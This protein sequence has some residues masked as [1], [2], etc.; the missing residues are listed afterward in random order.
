MPKAL[1]QPAC[2]RRQIR[3][4]HLVIQVGRGE[5]IESEARF[6]FNEED[7]GDVHGSCDALEL[8]GP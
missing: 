7:Y 5:F 1:T 8:R 6:D 2:Y 4:A 3:F